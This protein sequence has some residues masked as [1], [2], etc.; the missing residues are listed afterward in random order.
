MGQ[1]RVIAMTLMETAKALIADD[2][3]LLAMEGE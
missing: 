1:S 2:K 3:G